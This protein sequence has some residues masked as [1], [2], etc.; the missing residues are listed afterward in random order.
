MKTKFY[1]LAI[2]AAFAFVSCD[3][4]QYPGGSTITEE[5]YNNMDDAAQGTVKGVYSLLY[6]YG[7]QHDVFG[8][9]S[10]DLATDLLC[11]DIAMTS[12]RYG[13]F[14]DDEYGRTYGRAGYFWSFYYNIIRSCN[15]AINALDAQG[16]IP[17]LDYDPKTITEQEFSNGFYYAE[18]LTIRGW[19]YAALQRFFCKTNVDLNTEL[20]VP[21]YTE[22]A[23]MDDSTLGAPRSTASDVYRRVEDDLV[24]AIQYFETFKQVKLADGTTVKMERA[25]KLEV[26]ADVARMTLA[27]SYLNKGENNN[28]L[29]VA[30][31]LIKTTTATILPN[32]EVLTS[33]FNDVSS[34]NWI[35]GEDVTIENTTALASFFGQCD[36]YSYSYASAGDVKG[37]DSKL[38]EDVTKLGWDVREFW[39]G[40]YY[41]NDPTKDNEMYKYAPDGKFFSAKSDEL[42]GDRDWLSDNVFMRAETAYLIAAEAAYRE[43]NPALAVEYLTKITDERVKAG[44]E[45]EY[46][47]YKAGL[48]A[49]GDALKEAIR[50][51]WRVELWG[52]GYGL[53]TFRRWGLSVKLGDNHL[54]STNDP[55][56]PTTDRVFTFVIP[57][58]ETNYNPYISTTEMA[59]DNN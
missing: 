4:N 34:N 43:N 28:A 20:S 17:E 30:E 21:V 2:F 45:T 59:T 6:A 41:R 22:E 52:E 57:S 53:Q 48:A 24:T 11:G 49:G 51:N 56:V 33:G 36:I 31:D 18:L 47:A 40:N 5:Q 25:S 26:N 42:Q 15:K 54:R 13:W 19:A 7:G 35:W 29:L 8:Q 39:W 37:I 14:V 46:E 10:I 38:L 27:Y 58:S 12:K 44:K 50:Y 3:L 32:S 9:R 55:L 23:T 1:I 16:G